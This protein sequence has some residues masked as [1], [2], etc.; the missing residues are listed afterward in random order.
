ML[1]WGFPEAS[2]EGIS[3]TQPQEFVA[4]STK[5]VCPWLVL[6]AEGVP[7]PL[8]IDE[9]FP[10]SLVVEPLVQLAFAWMA[11]LVDIHCTIS[12]RTPWAGILVASPLNRSE[13]SLF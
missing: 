6:R 10:K 12:C 5:Q 3:Q 9:D 13:I 4:I 7:F 11:R 1:Y 8:H 2:S